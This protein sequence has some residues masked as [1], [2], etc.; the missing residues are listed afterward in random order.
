MIVPSCCLFSF[1]NKSTTPYLPL[2]LNPTIVLIELPFK[3]NVAFFNFGF[4]LSPDKKG[5]SD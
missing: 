3:L 5:P 2:S 1:N 4:S